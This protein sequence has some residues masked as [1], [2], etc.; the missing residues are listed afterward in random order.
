MEI[1]QGTKSLG[2]FS[3]RVKDAHNSED[4]MAG[5]SFDLKIIKPADI[6]QQGRVRRTADRG[7]VDLHLDATDFMEFTGVDEPFGTFAITF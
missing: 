4:Y 3:F 6:L 2:S 7:Q 5:L 1:V